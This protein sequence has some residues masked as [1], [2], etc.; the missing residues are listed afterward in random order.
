MVSALLASPVMAQPAAPFG[1]AQAPAGVYTTRDQPQGG[2]LPWLQQQQSGTAP[3]QPGAPAQYTPFQRSTPY[4]S[5]AVPAPL[6]MERA[7]PVEN[8]DG[9]E[10]TEPAAPA[11][12]MLE[13]DPVKED[14]AAPTELTAPMF[15]SNG[16]TKTPRQIVL[17]VLNKVTA[18]AE[19]LKAKPGETL[20]FGKLEIEAVQ[21]YQS[22][23]TSLPD[24]VALL[25]IRE[26]LADQ[27]RAKL[28]FHGWM[29]ASTPSLTAL[30]H[31]I[32]D[33]TMVECA[34]RTK[35]ADAVGAD[36]DKAKKPSKTAE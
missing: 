2:A 24:S 15:A 23:P 18:R 27:K 19:E 35:P 1:Q 30:E 17:R 9:I 5:Q 14:P 28:L 31:P 11:P 26:Q 22:A 13:A 32:Y 10:V 3:A 33:V 4:G 7:V 36:A 6:P 34:M 29:Y 20:K 12:A 16:D 8:I 25:S 21:C